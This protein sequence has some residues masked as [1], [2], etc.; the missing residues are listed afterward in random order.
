MYRL[1]D[2]F[3]PNPEYKGPE[4]DFEIEDKDHMYIAITDPYPRH[5][6]DEAVV[7]ATKLSL[8]PIRSYN[9]QS[10]N[11]EEYCILTP[12]DGNTYIKHNTYVAFSQAFEIP[13][14]QLNRLV[15]K[16]YILYFGAVNEN[17]QRKLLQ[18]YYN[19]DDLDI[20]KMDII[21]EQL[22]SHG[23]TIPK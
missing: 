19:L 7:L 9:G 14:V 20:H 13:I 18:G 12:V 11:Q 16:K 1:G 4:L 10:R 22:K 23:F 3:L 17:G 5:R 2:I 15:N 6:D 8:A 21:V